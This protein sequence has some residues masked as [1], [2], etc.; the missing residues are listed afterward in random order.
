M[1]VV[2]TQKKLQDTII[3]KLIISQPVYRD[4]AKIADIRARIRVPPDAPETF[5]DKFIFKNTVIVWPEI[6]RQLPLPLDIE[7]KFSY[8][9][10]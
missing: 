9:N 5:N 1:R 4:P 2:W 10:S 8:Y 7:Q 3:N 6:E